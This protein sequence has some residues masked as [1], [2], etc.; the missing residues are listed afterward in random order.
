[1]GT[2][3]KRANGSFRV[4]I[5]RAGMREESRSFDTQREAKQWE[6]KREAELDK[7]V[8]QVDVGALTMKGLI[9]VYRNMRDAGRPIRD[10]TNEHYQLKTIERLLGERRVGTLTVNDL[11]AYAKA[12]QDEGAGPYTLNMDLSKIGTVFRYAG[13]VLQVAL[14]DVVGAVR[15]LLKHNRVIG[16]GDRRERR[17][18]EDEMSRLLEHMTREYGVKFADA[19]RFAALSAMRRGEIVALTVADVD[20][21]T[22]CAHVMRKHPRLGKKAHIV[23]ILP[24]AWEVLQRQPKGPDGRFFPFDGSTLSKYFTDSCRVLGIP[25]LHLHDMRHE[26]VSQMIESG[27]TIGEA[28]LVSGHTDLRNFKI[29]MNLKPAALAQRA[30]AQAAASRTESKNVATSL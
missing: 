9:Q 10:D 11:L 25:D 20:A 21:T 18:T 17:P 5:R 24:A 3:E 19:V 16:G 15:P 29:Y 23:P 27:M 12:R 26:G 2:I 22:F 4:K 13:A 30:H 1:V 6:R 14:P 7:G 8:G 28:Q